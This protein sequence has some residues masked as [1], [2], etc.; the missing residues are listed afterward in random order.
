MKAPLGYTVRLDVSTLYAFELFD[1][2]HAPKEKGR[3][4]R[5][6]D[7][8][9]HRV[10]SS[11][12]LTYRSRPVDLPHPGCALDFVGHR[13]QPVVSQPCNDPERQFTVPNASSLQSVP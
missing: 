2:S 13:N 11:P 5:S 4:L 3:G 6:R 8:Q 10:F 1:L 9:C 7:P 12:M